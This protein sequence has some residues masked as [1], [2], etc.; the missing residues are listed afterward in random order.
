MNMDLQFMLSS[1]TKDGPASYSNS[2]YFGFHE[3]VFT[4]GFQ[5][6]F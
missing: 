4:Y 2:S 3:E 5:Y 1:L 6:I